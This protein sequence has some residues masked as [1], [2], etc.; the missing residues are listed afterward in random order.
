MFGRLVRSVF[1]GNETP[2]ESGEA[3]LDDVLA[4]PSPPLR[5]L[6]E[7]RYRG[8]E[9]YPAGWRDENQAMF[10]R[11]FAGDPLPLSLA[12]VARAV[13]M[14]QLNRRLNDHSTRALQNV[15]DAAMEAG[16][17]ASVAR[18]GP[19][20]PIADDQLP[21]L[22]QACAVLVLQGKLETRYGQGLWLT[23]IAAAAGRSRSP[24]VRRAL[25]GMFDTI[26]TDM[27]WVKDCHYDL[28]TQLL[29]VTGLTADDIPALRRRLNA[30]DRLDAVRQRIL[31]DAGEPLGAAIGTVLDG[32]FS[33]LN[34]LND[35]AKRPQFRALCDLDPAGRGATFTKALDIIGNL[36][37]YGVQNWEELERKSDKYAVKTQYRKHLSAFGLLLGV[38]ATRKLELADPDA[39]VARFVDLI[40]NFYSINHKSILK[41]ILGVARAHPQ[42]KTVAA[43]RAFNGNVQL[44]SSFKEWL[45]D[46]QDLL[47]ELPASA[48]TAAPAAMRPSVP[49]T[50]FGRKGVAPTTTGQSVLPGLPPI[51]LPKFAIDRYRCGSELAVHFDNLFDARLYDQPHRDF[52]ARLAAL[53]DGIE[54]TSSD[55]RRAQ[56]SAIIALAERSGLTLEGDVDPSRRAT[57]LAR[58]AEVGKDFDARFRVFA[59]FVA[60]H[61]EQARALGKLAA[62]IATKSAPPAKW[63]ADAKAALAGISNEQRLAMLTELSNTPSPLAGYGGGEQY[64]RALLYTSADL[65]PAIL[66]PR[67]ADYALKRC[68]V[69][70]AGHGI[71]A[72]KLGNACLWTLAAMPGGAGVPYL[73]RILARTKY[74]KIRAK[75]DEKLN[76]AAAAAGISRGALDEMTVP[77]HDLSPDGTCETALGGGTAVLRV[78]GARSVAID[79]FGDNGKPLKAPSTAMKAEKAALKSVRDAA[80]EIES[81]LGTQVVRLQRI[82]LDDRSWSDGEWRERYLDHPLMRTLVRRLIWSVE[83]ADG[84]RRSAMPDEA[85]EGLRDATGMPVPTD[86]ATIRLWHPIDATVDE[87]IAWRDRLETLEIV[88]P[89]AQAWR[90]VYA[91]TD[92]ERTTRTYSNRW[93]AHIL[94]QHQA[95]TLAR[96]NGWRTTHR[97]WVDAP[98]DEPWHLMIPAHGLVADY[99]VEGA[100]GDDPDVSES[101]AYT[102]INTDRVQFHAIPDG[103]RDSARG[104]QRDVAVPLEDV[105][106]VVFSEIMR[107]A[108]LLTSVASIAADPNWLDRGGDAAHPNQWGQQAADYW[109]QTNTA[110]LAESGKRRR[111]MLERVIPRLAIAPK[112]GFDD[113][114]LTVQGMRHNYRIHMGSGACFRGQRHICIVPKTADA[115][116]RLWLPFEGDRTLSIILSKAILLAAD[117]KI[118]DP[119]ILRQL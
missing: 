34:N 35:A 67:L 107:H 32:N 55:D 56:I 110:D 46:I 45:P 118:S 101:G 16:H 22:L 30:T 102:F 89:F 61:P 2:R 70:Q 33:W 93:A 15:F 68:Y 63:L 13:L 47:R 87:V 58:T 14:N 52:L 82:Y 36:P 18:H 105:P 66:G 117:D 116:D 96:L 104:P 100:G 42:G 11:V 71:R 8:A 88:Q 50:G 19:N 111:A 103:A 80:K 21:L 108:D 41:M 39:T 95:M 90:E 77:T 49:T 85:G 59:P 51:A 115:G 38:L 20:L 94:K 43:L 54:A 5:A 9:A 1:G 65:D 113:P 62:Q 72:E 17:A 74:P 7:D 31:A 91:L 109:T 112:V 25:L 73:A 86:G 40:P 84:S 57:A 69:T 6:F 78:D 119:V 24:A 99:W 106:P 53:S 26:F 48:P 81:D 12:L 3:R 97:M 44:H 60:A 4:V 98:N 37:R 23:P 76:E 92:A 27:D 83:M 79:W 10:D 28:A 29:P 114:Y 75:I 64:L